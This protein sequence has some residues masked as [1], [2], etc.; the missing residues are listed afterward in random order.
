[1]TA[2]DAARAAATDAQARLQREA[3]PSY[4][5]VAHSLN[6][7]HVR[8]G[9]HRLDGDAFLLRSDSGYGFHY[10]RGLGLTIERPAEHDPAEEALWRNGTVYAAIAALNGLRPLHASAVEWQGR[11]YAFTGPSGAGKSTL[12]AALGRNGYPMFCDDTLVLDLSCPDAVMCLPGHKRLKLTDEA[13]E[14]TGATPQER[15]APD[16]PKRFAVP[17]SGVA[18]HPLPLAAL[19]VLQEGAGPKAI[20]ARGAE[21]IALLADDHYT[22]KLYWAARSLEPAGQ[23]AEQAALA[24][25]IVVERLVRP[26]DLALFAQ[27]VTAVA[28]EISALAA[29]GKD[30]L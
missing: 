20:R 19:F 29:A 21:R 3:T 10:R 15:V 17:A 2:T 14:L 6:N 4:G 8:P 12:T 1:M 7:H 23:F 11:V 28:R 30:S 24:S 26:R 13:M 16:L 27:S 9:F 18:T 22:Q 5:A 25:R